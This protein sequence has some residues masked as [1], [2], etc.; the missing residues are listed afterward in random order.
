M[1]LTVQKFISGTHTKI[2]APKYF[3]FTKVSW[4]MVEVVAAYAMW[5]ERGSHARCKGNVSRTITYRDRA[6]VRG[7]ACVSTCQSDA[8]RVLAIPTQ[9]YAHGFA[10]VSLFD[11]C[12]LTSPSGYTVAFV[13]GIFI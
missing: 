10:L 3:G 11:R 12:M 8:G 7:H 9:T 5:M 2:Q 4:M 13:R 1:K 6:M